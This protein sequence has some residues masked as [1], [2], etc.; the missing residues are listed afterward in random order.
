MYD[1]NIDYNKLN[2]KELSP[3]ANIENSRNSGFSNFGSPHRAN[4]SVDRNVLRNP[5]LSILA[6][7][8][9]AI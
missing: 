3:T 9:C 6:K 5:L 8:W 2:N 7:R 1:N 4:V